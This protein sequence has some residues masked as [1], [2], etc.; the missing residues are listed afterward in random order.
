MRSVVVDSGRAFEVPVQ[1]QAYLAE[2]VVDTTLTL[3]QMHE[4]I[5]TALH[6]GRF[7]P[8]HTHKPYALRAVMLQIYDAVRLTH[9][10]GGWYECY[11]CHTDISNKPTGLSCPTCGKK[12]IQNFKP[13]EP[14]KK[15][16]YG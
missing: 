9:M 14:K 2:I 4:K 3:Q 16:K 10:F 6:I 5:C 8:A 12:A 11:H 7:V 1:L 13:E 15:P